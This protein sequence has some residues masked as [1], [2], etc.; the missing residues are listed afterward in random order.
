MWCPWTGASEGTSRETSGTDMHQSTPSVGVLRAN[1]LSW[2]GSASLGLKMSSEWDG[3]AAWPCLVEG[4]WRARGSLFLKPD[5]L[6]PSR[7]HCRAWLAILQLFVCRTGPVMGSASP[8]GTLVRPGSMGWPRHRGGIPPS[9]APQ[10][11]WVCLV[12]FTAIDAN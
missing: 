11:D 8:T 2:Q 5:N 6:S 9:W 7:Q 12:I 3:T 4:R 1:T 10:M